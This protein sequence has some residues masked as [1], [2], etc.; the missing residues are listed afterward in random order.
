MSLVLSLH[1]FV[2]LLYVRGPHFTEPLFT[3]HLGKIDLLS[4][5][6]S[7]PLIFSEEAP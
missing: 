4:P 7:S 2:L 1:M 3:F 5:P 6:P